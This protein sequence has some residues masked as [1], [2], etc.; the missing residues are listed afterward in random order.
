MGEKKNERGKVKM[1]MRKKKMK[2]KKKVEEENELRIIGMC[3]LHI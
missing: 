1:M 2:K 3:T